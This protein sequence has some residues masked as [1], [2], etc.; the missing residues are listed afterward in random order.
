MEILE[1]VTCFVRNKKN[2]LA[3]FKHPY[4]GVQIP[5][6]TVEFGESPEEAALREAYEETG[7]H[8]VK[9]VTLLDSENIL[10]HDDTYVVYNKAT[11][12]ARPDA[13][14]FDWASIR[15]GIYV[16]KNREENE[17]LHV[18]YRE[19][20][21]TLKPDYISYE[22]TGWANR[23]LLTN[24]I[25][26]YFFLLST[27]VETPSSWTVRTDNHSFQL[28]WGNDTDNNTI[29]AEQRNWLHYLEMYDSK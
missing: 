3:L 29:Q 6:G 13:E 1:K 5:A 28:F 22:I 12:H 21:D 24:K 20:N 10:L 25:R 9:I 27:S 23:A 26:R 4:A 8:D 7:L 15:R 14:S 19:M 16:K 2:Q 11:I 18:T 17:W